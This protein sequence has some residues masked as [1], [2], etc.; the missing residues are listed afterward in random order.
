MQI[1]NGFIELLSL[2][3]LWIGVSIVLNLLTNKNNDNEK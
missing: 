3:P 2:A 1:I